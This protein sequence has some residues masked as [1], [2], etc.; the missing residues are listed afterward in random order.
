VND[1]ATLPGPLI[2]IADDHPLVRA[3][4][5][6]T[7][8][9]LEPPPRFVEGN[10]GASA[11]ALASAQPGPD[12]LLMDLKM[13]GSRGLDDLRMLRERFPSM[14]IIVVS[15]DDAPG[16]VNAVVALGVAGFIPKSDAA[17]VIRNAVRIVLAGGT[18]VPARFA[19][20]TGNGAA[21]QAGLTERQVEV[22]RLLGSGR[23][24]KEIARELGITEGTVKVHLLSVFRALGVRNRTEAVLAAQR[25]LD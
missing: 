6:D 9:P 25:M 7:L 20:A 19:G 1:S 10:D 13:P 24:N 2:A 14:P 21:A 5:R 8:A 4:L 23:S 22:L 3:A 18:Y 11:L 16:T 15:A 12:L 17:D